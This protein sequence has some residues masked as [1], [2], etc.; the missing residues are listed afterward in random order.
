MGGGTISG[1]SPMSLQPDCIRCG[2]DARGGRRVEGRLDYYPRWVWLGLVGGL[3]PVIV[4]C[5]IG[6]KKL[7]ISF[8][9]CPDCARR[10]RWKQGMAAATWV[11]VAASILVSV[12]LD[13]AW[14]LIGTAL[15][16]V[17]AIVA[18]VLGSD[19]LQVSA[20]QDR[21]F[22]VKGFGREFPALPGP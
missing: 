22:T 5:F 2:R 13:D 19:P 15:L 3:L 20:Y 8:S 12:K 11:L 10:Q 17:G 9:L 4:L 16:F 1:T 6:R 18:S 7:R 14:I 21:V